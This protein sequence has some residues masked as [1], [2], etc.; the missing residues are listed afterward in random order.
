[1]QNTLVKKISLFDFSKIRP[2]GAHL[3]SSSGKAPGPE[4]LK[5]A[6]RNI[7]KI[8]DHAVTSN[9]FCSPKERGLKTNTGIRHSYACCGCSKFSGGVRRSATICVFSGD[10]TEMAQAKT[11]K[12]VLTKN[13][14][15]GRS[16]NSALLLRNETSKEQFS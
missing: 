2:A 3:S 8:L 4:P 11:G 15:R 9:E 1:M 16:N 13:P 10:D 7:R 5:K 6:L 14:Q 12:L